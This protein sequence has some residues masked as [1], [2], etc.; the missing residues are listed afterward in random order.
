MLSTYLPVLF[1]LLLAV[2]FPLGILIT[3]SILGPK[4]DVKSKTSPYEC[5][6]EVEGLTGERLPIKFYRVAILFLIFDV[7]AAFLF[8]WAVLFRNK[9]DSWGAPFLYLEL[10]VFL[11]ILVLGYVYAW[12]QGALEWD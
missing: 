9:I 2:G 4:V 8:P 10:L 6:I 11:F 7:E 1:L 3:S 5:G 12:R